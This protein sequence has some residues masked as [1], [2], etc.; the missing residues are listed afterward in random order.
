MTDIRFTET[1]LAQISGNL[2][3]GAV[4]KACRSVMIQPSDKFDNLQPN[5]PQ[6]R[7]GLG[8]TEPNSDTKDPVNKSNKIFIRLPSIYIPFFQAMAEDYYRR[9]KISRPSIGLLT[10]K[11]LFMAGHSW[12]RRMVLLKNVDYEG[13]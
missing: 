12:N 13:E 5:E 10:K 6:R 9:N 11:C 4:K 8:G 7:D 2:F 1:C 3:K